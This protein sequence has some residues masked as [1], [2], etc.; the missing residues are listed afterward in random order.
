MC[1]RITTR[2][3]I[4]PAPTPSDLVPTAMVVSPKTTEAAETSFS[5]ALAEEEEEA[6]AAVDSAVVVEEAVA[7]EAGGKGSLL[8][9]SLHT[10]TQC[11]GQL[12]SYLAINRA[13]QSSPKKNRSSKCLL[14]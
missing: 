7:D 9:S 10:I 3:A 5:V 6:A 13:I 1:P 8:L 14:E 12:A 2:V 11:T 4:I